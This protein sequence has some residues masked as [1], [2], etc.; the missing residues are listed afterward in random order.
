MYTVA[1]YLSQSAQNEPTVLPN[2][3]G[4]S[5]LH[6]QRH[7]LEFGQTDIH[8][9]TLRDNLQ[10]EDIDAEAAKLGISSSTWPLFG[11]LW[12]SGEILARIMHT[13]EI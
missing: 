13:H 8:V 11:V 7:T 9:R 12:A 5:M 1:S 6:Y 10:F 2:K 4:F 3:L